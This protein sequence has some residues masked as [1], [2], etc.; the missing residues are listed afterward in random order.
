M[1]I[2]NTTFIIDTTDYERFLKWIRAAVA[3]R[4]M[5]APSAAQSIRI[6]AVTQIVG[7]HDIDAQPR[8]VA[9]QAEFN[10]VVEAHHWADNTLSEVLLEYVED[11]GPEALCFS[12]VMETIEV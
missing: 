8:S 4:L 1:I 6:A 3:C 11:F 2:Y 9:L 12:T 5:S 10:S 7:Q